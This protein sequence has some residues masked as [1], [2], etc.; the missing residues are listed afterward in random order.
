MPCDPE[1]QAPDR[2]KAP[3]TLA[4]IAR[5]P[6]RSFGSEGHDL[7]QATELLNPTPPPP[8]RTCGTLHC[9]RDRDTSLLLP[10]SSTPSH[11]Q[12][13]AFA[14]AIDRLQLHCRVASTRP[15]D[16]PE[17]ADC[18]G[19]GSLPSHTKALPG[20]DVR[21]RTVSYRPR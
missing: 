10:H 2:R 3:G 11:R 8:A 7:A 5:E 12:T 15:R 1:T 18:P 21:T 4:R 6:P 16:W 20:R 13:R 17:Y 19:P 9:L 14:P